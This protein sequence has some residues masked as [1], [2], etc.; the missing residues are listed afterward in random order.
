GD[1]LS[2]PHHQHRSCSEYECNGKVGRKSRIADKSQSCQSIE[3]KGNS[4]C[5]GICQDDCQITGCLIQLPP[6]NFPLFGPFFELWQNVHL[7]K[8]Y[9]NRSCNVGGNT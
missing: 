1:L 6:S 8:L 2:H 9:N 4:K 3:T 7:K 5:L